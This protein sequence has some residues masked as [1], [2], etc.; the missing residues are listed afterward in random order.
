MIEWRAWDVS[1]NRFV[2]VPK[3]QASYYSLLS[4]CEPWPYITL[5]VSR[6]LMQ[7]YEGPI[8]TIFP[9]H[10]LGRGKKNQS[11]TEWGQIYFFLHEGVYSSSGNQILE[12]ARYTTDSI[13]QFGDQG[14]FGSMTAASKVGRRGSR[15]TGWRAKSS[16]DF[17]EF[18]LVWPVQETG[19]W[20]S[21][22]PAAS[23][24]KPLSTLSS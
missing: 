18:Y 16:W 24:E 2:L 12:F 14:S 21:Q 15:Q 23:A 7:K 22:E 20:K 6:S 19:V 9:I 4:R 10:W 11:K 3:L 5:V 1:E 13:E 17:E 8:W